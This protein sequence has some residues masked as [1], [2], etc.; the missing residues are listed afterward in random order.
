MNTEA[1]M[2]QWKIRKYEYIF[3]IS[4]HKSNSL[5]IVK[6]WC[7]VENRQMSNVGYMRPASSVVIVTIEELHNIEQ[8]Q[9][10]PVNI[11][12]EMLP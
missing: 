2:S 6:P 8:N 7:R 3:H 11:G 1:Y 5:L 12:Q 9:Q 4:A 10:G